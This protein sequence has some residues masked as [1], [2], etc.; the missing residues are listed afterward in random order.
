MPVEKGKEAAPAENATED[1]PPA[2]KD[3]GVVPPP[4]K[5]EVVQGEEVKEPTAEVS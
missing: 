5:V 2:Y 1:A 4:E 3:E